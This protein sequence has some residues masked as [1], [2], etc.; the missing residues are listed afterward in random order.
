MFFL[1]RLLLLVVTLSLAVT[2]TA[3]TAHAGPKTLADWADYK[4]LEKKIVSYPL[5]QGIRDLKRAGIQVKRVGLVSFYIVDTGAYKFSAMAATYGGT[6]ATTHKLTPNGANHFA[7]RLAEE[8]L[9]GMKKAFA[10]HGMELLTP[11]EFLQNDEQVAALQNFELKQGKSAK[12]TR[13]LISMFAKRPEMTASANGFKYI[14]AAL[15]VDAPSKTSMEELRQALGLDALLVVQNRT[16]SDKKVVVHGGTEMYLFGR[17]P[18]PLPK[19]KLARISYSTGSTYAHALFAK[20][21]K[22][23]VIAKMGKPGKPKTRTVFN[24]T[25]QKTITTRE[26]GIKSENYDGFGKVMER[27]TN[28]L[29][30]RYEKEYAKGKL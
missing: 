18:N 7:T 25:D 5:Q 26:R 3:L 12:V 4:K 10:A 6:Y 11:E 13:K 9:P 24:G 16:V 17:N 2:G 15:F 21:Y 23:S 22:G 28:E 1:R 30:N 19:Q 27:T 8:A 29:L 20:G 14:P